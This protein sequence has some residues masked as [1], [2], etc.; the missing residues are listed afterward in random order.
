MFGILRNNF[1]GAQREIGSW[2]RREEQISI[3]ID[4]GTIFILLCTVCPG[5]S[6]PPEKIFHMFAS[7]KEVYTIFRLNIVRL[8]SKMILGHMNSIG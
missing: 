8:Q 4:D 1:G 7:E 6:D 2:E 3:T 5:S